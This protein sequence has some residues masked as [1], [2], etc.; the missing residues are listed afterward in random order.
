MSRITQDNFSLY[1]PQ[2]DRKYINQHERQRVL[3]LM[4]ERLERERALFALL[5][6]WTGGRISEILDVRPSSFQLDR[7]IVALRTLKRRRPHVREI[8]IS[9]ELMRALDQQF[10]L[11]ALQSNPETANER[12]WRWSRI[13]AWRFVKGVMMDAGII[14]RAAC[15]RGLRHGFGVGTLQANVPLNLVQRWM[16]HARLTT[17]AIYADVSGDEEVNFAAMFW[18]TLR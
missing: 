18:R 3:K 17:T 2:G 6:A 11:R 1:S 12:L 15:P 13:T 7:S 5:L 14:G 10:D 4:E 8:P 9:P 16:G